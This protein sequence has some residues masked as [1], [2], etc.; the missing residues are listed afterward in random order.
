MTLSVN[1]SGKADNILLTVKS[2]TLSAQGAGEKFFNYDVSSQDKGLVLEKG[3]KKIDPKKLIAV[4]GQIQVN[5]SDFQIDGEI[6]D[7]KQGKIGDCYFLAGLNAITNTPNGRDIIKNNIKKNGNSYSVKLP[8]AIMASAEQKRDGLKTFI[9]GDYKISEAELK[10]AR[11]SGKYSKGDDDVLV[12]ELAFEKYREEVIATNKANKGKTDPNA[13]HG[14]YA[15]EYIGGGTE[16]E[17]LNGG[18]GLD[19]MFL[20][21]GR[22]SQLYSKPVAKG[23]KS[24]NEVSG[25]IRPEQLNSRLDQIQQNPDKYAVTAGF[26]MKN[27][28][29]KITGGHAFSIKSVD[30][31]FVY[32][33]NPW[34][35]ANVV[36]LTREQ[37]MEKARS[38]EMADMD[39]KKNGKIDL[40][41][42]NINNVRK[43]NKRFGNVINQLNHKSD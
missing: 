24:I 32:L 4:I 42:V 13:R 22:K 9:T 18:K 5:N 36:K 7:F 26:L 40:S 19:A 14:F 15:G 39:P 20:L 12:M 1:N 21:T 25:K 3:D 11:K 37:F 28:E 29:G 30:D 31:K 35:S 43:P 8:G 16:D 34:D 17:P 2:D 41:N 38:M 6:G 23:E 27:K 33:V 10:E